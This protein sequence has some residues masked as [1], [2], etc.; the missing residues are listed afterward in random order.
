MID[1][2]DTSLGLTRAMIEE[3]EGHIKEGAAAQ[4]V[5]DVLDQA[6]DIRLSMPTRAD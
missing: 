6:C 3:L 4:A 1:L 5:I 2:V